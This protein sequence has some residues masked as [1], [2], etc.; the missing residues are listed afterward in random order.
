[1]IQPYPEV[2]RGYISPEAEDKVG[3]LADVIRAIRNLRTE[4]NCQP[5]KQVQVVLFGA[6]QEIAFLRSQEAYLRALARSDSVEYQTSGERPKGAT[7]AMVRTT[8]IYLPLDGMVDLREER[9]RLLKEISKLEQELARAQKKLDNQSFLANAKEEVV[10]K[11]KGKLQEFEDKL[12]TLRRSL[13]RIQESETG[14][15]A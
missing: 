9:G 7:T 3:F 14:A 6:D 13:Q 2:D 4:M 8:E 11:E 10:E 5:S 15:R 12:Q 1:M